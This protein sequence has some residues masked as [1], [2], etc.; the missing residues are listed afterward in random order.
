MSSKLFFKKR[1]EGFMV[2]TMV[3][4]VCATVLIISVGSLL[5]SITQVN[6][7]ADSLSSFKAWGVVNACGEYTL[8]QMVGSTSTSTTAANWNFASS[9]GVLLP[10]G[11]ETCYI[12][13]VVASGTNK[14]IQASST[15]SGF[16]KKILISVAT[17][18]PAIIVNSWKEVADFN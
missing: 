8:Q 1:K 6:S 5:R 3:L 14:L 2:L 11:S 18:T 7:T 15:V 17:N 4:L 9:T 12:Y 13:P 10:I 16:T